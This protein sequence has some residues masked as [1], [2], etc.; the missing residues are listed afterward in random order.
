MLMRL[1]SKGNPLL[2]VGLS[3]SRATVGNSLQDP[4]KRKIELP[5]DP[6]VLYDCWV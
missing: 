6:A 3:T 5:C 1:Q 4:Q 2:L